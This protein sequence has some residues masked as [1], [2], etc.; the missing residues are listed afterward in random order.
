M[1]CGEHGESGGGGD[2]SGRGENW[3]DSGHTLKE[4]PHH[5]DPALPDLEPK[6]KKHDNRLQNLS[7]G[8]ANL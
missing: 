4:T 2:G 8:G 5:L 3:L 6:D 1:G 7:A